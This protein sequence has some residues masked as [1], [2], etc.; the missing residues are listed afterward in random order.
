ML[1]LPTFIPLS[2]AARKYG[3]DEARLRALVEKG[4]IRAGVIAGEMVVSED[5]VKKRAEQERG[6]GA[7]KEDLPE[8]QQFSSLSNSYLGINEASKKYRIPYT[9]LYQWIRRGFISVKGKA[10]QKVLISEQDVAFCELIYRPQKK[11]GKK[12][13]AANGIPVQRSAL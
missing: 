7:R 5:E 9:T 4:K 12:I 2:E 6:S 8:Y 3:L 10:G 11:Q 1:T 13:F